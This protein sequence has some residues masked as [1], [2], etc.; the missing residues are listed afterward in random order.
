MTDEVARE[1]F[2]L[3]R[4]R[5]RGGY[6]VQDVE[7]VL[8]QLV[9]TVRRLEFDLSELRRRSGE[10]EAELKAA[11]QELGGYRA[12][13]ARLAQTLRRAEESL[14]RVEELAREASVEPSVQ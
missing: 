11:R 2:V 5:I 9:G 1:E 14:A 3:R 12:Q 6:R 7:S 4:R 8:G 10:L 13:E